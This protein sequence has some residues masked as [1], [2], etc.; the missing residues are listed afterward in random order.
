MTERLLNL[1]SPNQFTLTCISTGGP[2]TTV[3]WTKDSVNITEG[4][5]TVLDNRTTAQY[6]HTLTVT[7]RQEGIYKCTV[8][9]AFFN[10]SAIFYVTGE[11]YSNLLLTQLCNKWTQYCAHFMTF[12]SFLRWM[13]AFVIMHC[14][15]LVYTNVKTPIKCFGPWT[16]SRISLITCEFF[17][18]EPVA[19]SITPYPSATIVA[20][21]SLTL[22]CSISLPSGIGHTPTFQW[23]GPEG[24]QNPM[25]IERRVSSLT[26]NDVQPADA[27]VYS[28]TVTL[29]G[30]ITNSTTVNV[31]GQYEFFL[32]T[33]L[34]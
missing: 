30:S 4:T 16:F 25:L 24:N 1:S 32:T 3:M 22:N 15:I 18:T 29:G 8:S 31:Q 14:L 28:C 26:V 12:C 7:G 17:S 23:E 6:T 5:K 20:G 9:N 33:Y 2:A 19:V 21:G 11:I 34:Q 27:G 10:A 13:Q